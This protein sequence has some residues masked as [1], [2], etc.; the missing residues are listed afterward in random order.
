MTP[1]VAEVIDV[2]EL[3]THLGQ[4][5]VEAHVFLGDAGFAFLHLVRAQVEF[6]LRAV[7]VR[8]GT[9]LVQVRV[10]PAERQLDNPVYLVEE[11]V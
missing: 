11:Q 2:V 10:G 3:V 8:A 9:E 5:L 1:V 4:H 6:G 7:H